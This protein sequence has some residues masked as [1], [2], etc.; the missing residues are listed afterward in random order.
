M[1]AKIVKGNSFRGAIDYHSKEGSVQIGGN[2]AG[3]NPRELAREF[4]AVRSQNQAC[5]KPVAHYS[6]SL[7]PGE[8]L[9]D[10]QWND[11]ARDFLDHMGFDGVAHQYIVN[12]HTDKAHEHIH[13]VANRISSET[14]HVVSDKYDFKRAHEAC[15]R[16]EQKYGLQSVSSKGREIAKPAAAQGP[17]ADAMRAKIDDAIKRCRGDRDLFI[18]Q[19]RA[20]GIE[21][22]F[23]RQKTGRIAGATFT[24]DDSTTFKGSQLGKGYGWKAIDRRMTKQ[25]E[26]AKAV[27][28]SR[29][30][31]ADKLVGNLTNKLVGHLPGGKVV[32]AIAKAAQ[33]LDTA[34]PKSKKNETEL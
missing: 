14:G 8:H 18:G 32:K 19:L 27:S 22:K 28:A 30:G 34:A 24:A 29:P 33:Q 5:T 6:L 7:P 26:L 9:T 3:R 4:G 10:A 16:L 13:I 11:A 2:M 25:T 15:R 1:I 12:R 21:P 31:L 23:N 20:A 17:A